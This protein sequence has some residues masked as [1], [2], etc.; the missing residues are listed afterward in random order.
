LGEIARFDIIV[1]LEFQNGF[2][3][4][5]PIL[6]DLVLRQKEDRIQVSARPMGEALDLN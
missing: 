3:I 6:F 5:N 1:S 2:P 4:N